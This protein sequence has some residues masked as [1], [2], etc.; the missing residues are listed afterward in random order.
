MKTWSIHK[1][2]IG[3]VLLASACQ[4]Q[5]D[6]LFVRQEAG[7][8]GVAFENHL[9]ETEQENILAYEYFYNGG[10]V[11][12]G[13][14]NNDG[15][16]DLY[17]TGNQVANKLYLNKGQWQFDDV[18]Q[19]AG[20]AGRV[21]N[22][23]KT[24]V[25]IADVNADGWLD[26]YVCYS[27]NLPEA[28][29]RNQLFINNGLTKNSNTPT[30][31]EKAVEYGLADAGYS[32]QATFFDYDSDGDLDLFLLNHGLRDYERKEAA[33]LKKERDPFVGDKL[34]QNRSE[35][36]KTKDRG[37]AAQFVDVSAET[38]I[39]GN[40]LGYGLG[41]VVADLNGDNHPDLFVGNDYVEEDYVYLN[42]GDGSGFRE[43]GK[44]VLGHM[45]Y[46]T[47]GADIADVN[48]DALPDIFSVDMLPEDNAR[49]KSLA[50]PDNWN[51][52]L[53]MREHGFHNQFMRNM[54]HINQ[55]IKWE[56]NTSKKS[57]S[58]SPASLSPYFAEI[59]QLA[60]ISNTDWSWGGLFADFDN[61]GFQDLFVSNGYVRDYTN[62]DFVKYYADEQLKSEQG[63]TRA[64]LL[65]SLKQMPSTATH[66]YIFRNNGVQDGLVTFSNEVEKWGFS[67]NTIACGS[68]YADFDGDGD[69]DLVTNNTNEP[70]CLYRNFQQE[71]QPAHYLKIQLK[72]PA[73]NPFGLGTKV[74]AYAQ[75]QPHYRE[76]QPTHGFQSSM[77]DAVHIGLGT[78]THVDSVVIIWPDN[79][80]QTIVA[81]VLD[82][83]LTVLHPQASQRRE[84]QQL[85]P[86]LFSQVATSLFK[87]T[88]NPNIDFNRQI[89]LPYLYSYTGPRMAQGDVN[90]DG[91]ADVYI[92]GAAN[93]AGTLLIQ[94]ENEQL[95][96]TSQPA[97][98]ADKAHE[99]K[100]AV[101]FDADGD[102]DLD[103][104]VV[105]GEY[106]L[107]PYDALQQDRLYIN[108]GKGQFFRAA[109][110][111]FPDI[112]KNGSCVVAGD[113]DH[114]GDQ[115]LFIGG[116][117]SPG[118]F[119]LSTESQLF[120][121]DG[122][123][124]FS[125]D[126][127]FK[128]GIVTDATA[129][130]LNKD[131]YPELIVV[132]EWAAPTLLKGSWQTVGGQ[133]QFK[134]AT[135]T[136][137]SET[138]PTG[139]WNR[140]YPTDLDSDGDTDFVVGNLGLN[141]PFKPTTD[142]PV[143]LW[144]DDFDHNGTFDPIISYFIKDNIYPLA[145]RDELLEQLVPLRKKFTNYATYA[146]ATINDVLDEDQRKTA[147]KQTI[148]ESRSGVLE[149]VNGKF[150]FRPLPLS[151][152]ASPV[153]AIHAA[154]LDGDGRKDLLLAGNQ[155]TFRIR[156][157]RVDANA[158]LVLLNKGG[159]NFK[160]VPQYQTGLW[161][162]GDVR[163]IRQLGPQL[164][165][166]TNDG[167]LQ[168]YRFTSSKSR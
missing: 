58:F 136:L 124:R 137:A 163:D 61:D 37:A 57:T 111:Q 97:F 5:P 167:P 81:P 140:I 75:H 155:S 161:L 89:L 4:Q 95:L 94:Q 86:P 9:T 59:G 62:L 110:G 39:I 105:S 78:A 153:F 35:A 160:A 31:T 29:R 23:W 72:G 85:E 10:G 151:A 24:G 25:A 101:F 40:P 2:A 131:D 15:R 139:F 157:G 156:I 106:S 115:D 8:T 91:R 152:Q 154:D 7:N 67:H 12:V 3:I 143:T 141:T 148:A 55:G 122:K 69:V 77:V 56:W 164:L 125:A 60:G 80:Q 17:F 88:E 74:I 104:F 84:P 99:D 19:Q 145:S 22:A 132:G 32:T 135:A 48:N 117:V 51:V 134:L 54:L 63:Q 83:T 123:G 18:T 120:L 70:A 41:V 64:P 119:P 66:H 82:K 113:F 52:H 144:Y 108:N 34:F 149:N 100:D 96:P 79:R 114:D 92:G 14:F 112:T 130:D 103:L 20:V 128:L 116:S 36:V 93:Q 47:M 102:N 44:E 13:D 11:A 109:M 87:H 126:D 53:S 159:L 142:R 127:T 65:E 50:W 38:G 68:A 28:Q 76:M 107:Q 146:T 49:Q 147:Q 26:I 30:F 33:F 150:V 73:T 118:E 90:G 165:F 16:P 162:R 42:K 43:V 121:N 168:V 1:V 6:T 166:S 45:S 21:G 46:S 158:G 138:L 71:R 133:K 27:G 98:D 129:T